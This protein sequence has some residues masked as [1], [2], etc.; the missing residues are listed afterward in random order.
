[1]THLNSKTA[2]FENAWASY[3]DVE[4]T[5]LCV[6]ESQNGEK[7]LFKNFKIENL[8]SIVSNQNRITHCRVWAGIKEVNNQ[9]KITFFLDYSS[10]ENVPPIEFS[11]FD[12]SF[13]L[14]SSDLPNGENAQ[15]SN[16][17]PS[18]SVFLSW[19]EAGHFINKWNSVE[20]TNPEKL[21]FY[22]DAVDDDDRY[23]AIK[24]F[25]YS[26]YGVRIL[27]DLNLDESLIIHIGLDY[28]LSGRPAH[29]PPRFNLILQR[30]FTL[31]RV[32]KGIDYPS[33]IFLE[34]STPNP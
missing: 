4:F 1:M 12:Q 34:Y 17:V 24:Y 9:E 8:E 22:F 29:T 13:P 20:K 25:D 31:S 7:K 15:D 10:D 11:V 26:N 28:Y 6:S 23:Q 5:A 30:A 32:S 33:S 27:K 16:V 18:S 14:R 3:E 21:K 2:A 19:R